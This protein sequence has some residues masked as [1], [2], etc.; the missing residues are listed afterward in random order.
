MIMGQPT[1]SRKIQQLEKPLS[2]QRFI[3]ENWVQ[4]PL[5]LS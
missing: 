3:T 1:I 2:D 4:N 5:R